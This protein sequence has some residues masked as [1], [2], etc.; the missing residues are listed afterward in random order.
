MFCIHNFGHH[1]NLE[2]RK[3]ISNTSHWAP[4]CFNSP[5]STPVQIK[6]CH[7][8]VFPRVKSWCDAAFA[9]TAPSACGAS[10]IS[11]A[12]THQPCK[13]RRPKYEDKSFGG[14]ENY[15]TRLHL[16]VCV[17]A[18]QKQVSLARF[19]LFL[20]CVP[21]WFVSFLSFLVPRAEYT[22]SS[23]REA[24]LT[25]QTCTESLK[26]GEIWVFEVYWRPSDD[27]RRRQTSRLLESRP[28]KRAPLIRFGRVCPPSVV[29]CSNT[30]PVQRARV[31]ESHP[32][33]SWRKQAS[34]CR[35]DYTRRWRSARSWNSSI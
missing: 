35:S 30:L 21:R 23:S 11:G 24:Q 16:P 7:V 6:L 25:R 2:L 14:G 4:C 20:A 29:S 33:E 32:R 9:Q 10:V 18:L 13:S 26:K 19:S 31:K 1:V 5:D 27:A 12:P 17:C 3:L 34:D 8:S 15:L 28:S 22:S